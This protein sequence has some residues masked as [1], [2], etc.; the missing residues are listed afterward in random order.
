MPTLLAEI[1]RVSEATKQSRSAVMRRAI[2]AGLPVVQ[3]GTSADVISLDSELSQR[4]GP[5]KQGRRI[6]PGRKVILECI[7][8]GRAGRLQPGDA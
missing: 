7:R 3:A 6:E 8:T 2:S 5:D 1:D 4:R